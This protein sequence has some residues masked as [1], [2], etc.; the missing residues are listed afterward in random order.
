[1]SL[2]AHLQT[3]KWFLKIGECLNKNCN[4][5][6][7]IGTHENKIFEFS[8]TCSNTGFHFFKIKFMCLCYIYKALLKI[9]ANSALLL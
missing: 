5:V 8:L 1:M 6:G 3:C 7:I 4:F 9:A 2:E